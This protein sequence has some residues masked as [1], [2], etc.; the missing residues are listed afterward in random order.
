MREIWP[1]SPPWETECGVLN[2]GDLQS[3]GTHWT[4]YVKMSNGKKLYFDSFG[5]A[6]PPMEL[7]KY[8][9]EH[10]LFYN[11][12]RIQEFDDPPICGHLCLEVLR[13]CSGDDSNW[14][15]IINTLRGDKYSWQSWWY[16]YI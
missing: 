4:C 13:Q 7:V 14:N 6:P 15:T 1:E 16:N 3:D 12:I 2:L 5:N 8:L 9:G 11:D 10:D